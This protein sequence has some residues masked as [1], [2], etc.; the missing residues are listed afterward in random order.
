V[1]IRVTGARE[2]KEALD[3]ARTI[4]NSPLVK[5]AFF[6]QDPN[7][8]RIMAALGRSDCFF[9]SDRVSISFDDVL[10]VEKGTGLG[11]EAERKSAQIMQQDSFV[12]KIDL[13]DGGES[14]EVQTCDFSKEY[15][16]INAD[17]RS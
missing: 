14:G 9:H 4:A 16:E 6:G 7:W 3:A 13:H 8:G 11:A 5:T 17:Y 12:L 10:M 2:K 1:T 15:I